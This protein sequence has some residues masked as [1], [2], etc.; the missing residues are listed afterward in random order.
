MIH[1]KC[2][3]WLHYYTTAYWRRRLGFVFRNQEN[4]EAFSNSRFLN[5]KTSYEHGWR[6]GTGCRGPSPPMWI[7]NG[8]VKERPPFVIPLA[9]RDHDCPTNKLIKDIEVASLGQPTRDDWHNSS[10]V[11]EREDLL[12]PPA[13]HLSLSE[14]T[15]P[16]W[17]Q[18][19]LFEAPQF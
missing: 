13:C 9:H 6:A 16:R 17:H 15:L 7:R 8:E 1:E 4:K 19:C 12:L 10:T 11:L 5:L 18:N 2:L 14:K 3:P